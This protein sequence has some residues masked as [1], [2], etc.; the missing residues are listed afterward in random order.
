MKG[1]KTIRFILKFLISFI[2]IYGLYYS[3]LSLVPEGATWWLKKLAQQVNFFHANLSPGAFFSMSHGSP[4]LHLNYLEVGTLVPACT[5][6]R[7]FFL[8]WSLMIAIQGN[9]K[10][11]WWFR[12]LLASLFLH[13]SNLARIS[14]LAYLQLKAPEIHSY[15]HD[16]IFQGL[17][18]GSLIACIIFMFKT[19]R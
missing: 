4:I 16:F 12:L 3:I 14:L 1:G 7:I 5:G 2:L 18:Y 6:H 17:F 13:L 10:G 19:K 8:F 9:K 15:F 11:S